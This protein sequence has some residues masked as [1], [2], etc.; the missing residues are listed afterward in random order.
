MKKGFF[1]ALLIVL[2]LLVGLVS[3]GK[4]KNEKIITEK[5]T[6][7]TKQTSKIEAEEKGESI[8]H[9]GNDGA[10]K[11]NLGVNKFTDE[12]NERI[13]S[14]D[15]VYKDRIYAKKMKQYSSLDKSK[16]LSII[17]S[18]NNIVFSHN[19]VFTNFAKDN[20]VKVKS[21]RKT[22][23]YSPLF[24]LD[25]YIERDFETN[26]VT[27]YDSYGET[28][29]TKLTLANYEI[30]KN[31]K[32]FI[33]WAG[34]HN[35][36]FKESIEIV[37]TNG[38]QRI[39]LLNKINISFDRMVA[40]FISDD[41]YVFV[42]GESDSPTQKREDC[43]LYTYLF[44]AKGNLLWS[45]IIPGHGI[46]YGFKDY[47]PFLFFN[48]RILLKTQHNFYI[49]DLSGEEVLKLPKEGKKRYETMENGRVILGIGDEIFLIDTE[50]GN[51]IS[52]VKINEG[53]LSIHD[54]IFSE[55]NRETYIFL[56]NN[57]TIEKFKILNEMFETVFEEI[58]NIDILDKKYPFFRKS[59]NEIY[60]IKSENEI[61]KYS[62]KQE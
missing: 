52:N 35:P 47:Y 49:L 53:E 55:E 7:G 36:Y 4:K 12:I 56:S 46:Y 20:V 1:V 60:I 2:L 14:I 29:S 15:I 40:N 3:C 31:N 19:Y 30:S 42:F 62:R 50:D 9:E 28:R 27:I 17:S 43:K 32:Y 25:L 33:S 59:N 10:S 34:E 58:V 6:A 45:K 5:E 51:I 21:P 39:D 38:K 23:F 22:C 48:N 37:S 11:E 8:F 61:W 54:V 24:N 18:G 44:D 57:R 41:L 26:Y 13:K 16:P